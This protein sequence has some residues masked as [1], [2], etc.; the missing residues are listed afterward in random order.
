M[1]WEQLRWLDFR[2]TA[3]CTVHAG[4]PVWETIL[5]GIESDPQKRKQASRAIFE[6]GHGLASGHR[7]VPSA[8][9]RLQP[10]H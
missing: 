10:A 7:I 1:A 6:V 3:D 2:L 4:T 5:R 9:R 8:R